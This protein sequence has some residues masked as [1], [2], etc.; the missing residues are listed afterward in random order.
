MLCR[1]LVAESIEMAQIHCSLT[2]EDL[3][4][5]FAVM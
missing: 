2:T 1:N 3:L 4:K 5:L